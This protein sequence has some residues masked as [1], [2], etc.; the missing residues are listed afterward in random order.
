MSHEDF[1]RGNEN[2]EILGKKLAAN[3]R[4]LAAGTLRQLDSTITKERGLRM[5]VFN[6]QD[7]HVGSEELMVSH[8]KGLAQL[9]KLGVAV[10]PHTLCV[11]EEEILECI[12]SIGD[13]RGELEYDIDG[14]VIKIDQI[15]YREAFSGSSKYS[16][17]HIAYKYPPE[18]KEVEIEEIEVAVGRTGKMTFRARFKDAVKLC[19]T[20]VLRAT[21]HKADFIESMNI[22]KLRAAYFSLNQ[23]ISGS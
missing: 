11:T 21:L 18:E 16:A 5:Y 8:V 13:N 1:D 7:A 17:G 12:D 19:G 6:V 10:V 4:N 3:P 14:A 2:Q 15:E 23:S 22:G 9:A 20:S